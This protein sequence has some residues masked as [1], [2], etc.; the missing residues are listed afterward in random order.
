MTIVSA[1]ITNK[2]LQI[3]SPTASNLVLWKI[4]INFV[5][6]EYYEGYAELKTSCAHIYYEKAKL[7]KYA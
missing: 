3:L 6:F 2:K 1:P 7:I 5:R 4:F